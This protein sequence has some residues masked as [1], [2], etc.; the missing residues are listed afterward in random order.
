MKAPTTVVP[1]ALLLCLTLACP[2]L[3]SP[4]GLNN[5]PTTDIAPQRV[6]I[7]QGWAN[8]SEGEDTRYFVGA[9]SGATADLEVGLDS[10]ASPDGGPVTAQVKYRLPNDS[11]RPDFAVGFANLSAARDRAGQPMPYVVATQ[12]FPGWRAHAGYSGQERAAG[13]FLGADL[14][15]SASLLVRADWVRAGS[16][17]GSTSSIGAVWTPDQPFA[18]EAWA[19]FPGSPPTATVLTLKVDWPLSVSAP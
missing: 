5:I 19:S 17:T 7:L 14:R 11:T 10:K 13:F 1:I 6:V 8:S 4:S 12:A 2:C 18:L 16:S 3:P 9:K 15:V